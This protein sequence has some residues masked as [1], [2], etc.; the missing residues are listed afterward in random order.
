MGYCYFL[1]LGQQAVNSTQSMDGVIYSHDFQAHLL[2]P[3]GLEDA[4]GPALHLVDDDLAGVVVPR[5]AREVQHLSSG[6]GG[7]VHGVTWQRREARYTLSPL[8]VGTQY[9]K[10]HFRILPLSG[11][12]FLF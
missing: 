12:F 1:R 11:C 6:G 3:E 10:I 2:S 8:T 9:A 4:H 7:R 5:L